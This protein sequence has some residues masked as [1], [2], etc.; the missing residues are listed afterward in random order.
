MERWHTHPPHYREVSLC[1]L[2][3]AIMLVVRYIHMKVLRYLISGGAATALDLILLYIFTEFFGWW[4]LWSVTPAFVIAIWVSFFLQKFW[5]FND[6]SKD[7]GVQLIAYLSTA[8]INTGIN[9]GIVYACTEYLRIPYL[10][11]QI[12]SSAGIAVL[13]YFIYTVIIFKPSAKP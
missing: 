2:G 8:V 5:T 7:G 10:M 4:Y 9:A 13:S 12:L 6:Y 3:A 1:R 11:S